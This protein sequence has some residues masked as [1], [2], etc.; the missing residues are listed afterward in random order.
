MQS[1]PGDSAVTHAAPALSDIAE[2]HKTI[3]NVE[4][5]TV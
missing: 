1:R 4:S 2:A 3:T 5:A